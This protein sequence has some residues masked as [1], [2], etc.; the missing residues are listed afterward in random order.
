MIQWSMKFEIARRNSRCQRHTEG[1]NRTIKILVIE[2]I[3]IMP[4]PSRG[5]CHFVANES[6][7]IGSR[8][9][10]DSIDSGTSPGVDGSTH[11]HRGPNR[12]KGETR[13][14]ADTE[15]AV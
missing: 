12:R 11:S 8:L 15:L 6:N 3:F 13:R 7:A 5:I 1:L 10:F 4:N 14:A 2:R 9:R